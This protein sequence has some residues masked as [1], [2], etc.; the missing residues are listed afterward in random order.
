MGIKHEQQPAVPHTGRV[1]G[2]IF[3][4][5]KAYPAGYFAANIMNQIR[6][7]FRP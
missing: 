6:Q 7:P 3:L 5:E 4:N 1:A 2:F